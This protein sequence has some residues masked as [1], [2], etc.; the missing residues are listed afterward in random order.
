[1]P[2]RP[3]GPRI[4]LVSVEAAKQ[5]LGRFPNPEEA[6]RRLLT[7][8]RRARI[9]LREL[10]GVNAPPNETIARLTADHAE[11]VRELEEALADATGKIPKDGSVVVPKADADELV[12]W[13]KIG[14]KPADVAATVKKAGELEAKVGAAETATNAKTA[15]DFLKWPNSEALAGVISDKKLVLELR[16]ETVEG[17]TIKVPYVKGS[18]ENA[19]F[20]KLS[21]F[22]EKNLVAYLPAFKAAPASTGTPGSTSTAPHGGTIFNPQVP[23]GGTA[24]SSGGIA[25]DVLA[26]RNQRATSVGNA[27]RPAAAKTTT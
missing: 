14:T 20:S 1:M 5:F 8:Q 12:E 16:D 26:K 13:R 2:D 19:T 3:L 21:E 27:L 9:R 17:K 15:A 7:D 23:A 18:E 6:I 25:D 24:P 11:E 4:S 22:A 10:D